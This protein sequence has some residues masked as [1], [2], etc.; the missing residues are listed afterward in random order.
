MNVCSHCQQGKVVRVG[1]RLLSALFP[2]GPDH[3]QSHVIPTS[4]EDSRCLPPTHFLIGP[5]W[6]GG[7]GGGL[8]PP[9]PN[10]SPL[11]SQSLSPSLPIPPPCPPNPSPL[12]SPPFP[13]NPPPLERGR[14]EEVVLHTM[15]Q[16]ACGHISGHTSPQEQIQ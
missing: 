5:F 14:R 15:F 4:S 8:L 11:P 12:P 9:S 16:V 3:V 2:V 1:N 10:P 6:G 13:P 7:G